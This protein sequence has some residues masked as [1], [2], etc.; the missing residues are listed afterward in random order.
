MKQHLLSSGLSGSGTFVRKSL[1]LLLVCCCLSLTTFAQTTDTYHWKNVQINGGGFV[2]GIIYN[3]TEKDLLYARTD[4]GGAYRWNATT[5]TWVPLLD[6][7]NRTEE[8][9]TGV[10]SL[11]T[12]LVDP[13]RVYLATGLYSQAW[14]GTG[15]VLYSRDRGAT[16]AK[17]NLAVKLGG[18][19]DGR[20]TGERLQVDPHLNST[21]YLGT[22]IDG[23]WK[24]TTSGATW[25]KVN[26]FPVS[27]MAPGSG[28]IAFVLF[29]KRN[30]T[31]GAATQ[32]IYV[33]V[34]RKGE[35]NL[36]HSTDAGATWAAVPNQ[37]TEYMPHHAA[38]AA[39]GTLYITYADGPG[40]NGVTAG[41]V[42]KLNTT[43]GTWTT[44]TLP[45]GQGGFAG[46]AL[47]PQA[48]GTVMVSTLNRWWPR[49]EVY[50]STD[51]GTTWRPL[52]ETASFDHTAAPYAAASN[53]HW[54]GDLDIDPFDS[55][56]SWF[57]TGY[58]VFN[59]TNLSES[60][61]QRPVNWVFQNK[62]LEE[63]V[64]LKLISP[65]AGAHLVS[66]LG[67]IDGFRH[68]NLDE[69]PAA[70]R[71]T[72]RYGTNTWIDFA[73]NLP[74][75]MVRTHYQ[76]EAH[77]GAFSTDG[78]SN[79]APFANHPAGVTGGGNI[80]VTADGAAMIWAPAGV[81]SVYHSADRSVSWAA[82][83]GAGKAN[84]KVAADRVNAAKVYAYD[85]M[86]GQV[87]VSTNKGVSFSTGATGL[88][89]VANWQLWA[90]MIYPVPGV[91]GDIWLTNT[92]GGIYRSTNSG[93]SFTKISNVQ[94]ATKVGFGK[95][96]AGSTYPAVFLVGKVNN[97]IGFFRSDDAGATWL[98]INDDQHQFGGIND[99]TG[100]P[101]IFGRVYLATGG[102][103][104]IYGDVSTVTSVQPDQQ[105]DFELSY[106]PNPF[107]ER[108]HLESS[109]PFT[110]KITNLVGQ[111][112]AE[113]TCTGNCEVG[114][115]LQPGIYLLTVFQKNQTRT[116]RI[117]KK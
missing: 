57:V 95:A 49:D 94:E 25:S 15:T 26:S 7:L 22:T 90:S 66:A 83:A 31:A 104:I 58:G 6:H 77:F 67:D 44:L 62:G 5:T 107:N 12:D 17:S 21:L 23:L 54:L 79:W 98:R 50:R 46:L 76:S 3:Q 102:R 87:L 88:P 4:V 45:A 73:A 99:I 61:Q 41:A 86:A 51:A 106:W 20:S 80:A 71:L 82:S 1:G 103:G 29:D 101:R 35:N 92:V 113:G 70:G 115:Y 36:Y 68:D 53:P 24:S 81:S 97:T 33:G 65:P 43:T 30:G 64:P 47:D 105:Q 27:S 84:L 85:A 78:G 37:L 38:M 40:P 111:T 56:K 9:Y 11:A 75:F 72:P 59:S 52:L 48:P 13:D 55:N 39:D 16:W 100:D 63:T 19:E 60:D 110:Y 93:S 18:N 117:M 28:G 32:T 2:T 96:A 109:L 108:L 74:T 91:E 10:L 69:S 42:R 8:N 114:A 89:A 116:I 112:L 34:L 14:A